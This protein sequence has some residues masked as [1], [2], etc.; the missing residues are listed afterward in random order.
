[1]IHL[2][3]L[4]ISFKSHFDRYVKR[5][6]THPYCRF[7]DPLSRSSYYGNLSIETPHFQREQP[8]VNSEKVWM[9]TKLTEMIVFICRKEDIKQNL[10]EFCNKKSTSTIKYL[11]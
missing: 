1:M 5:S 6:V 4:R 2:G 8:K 11:V 9:L 10:V 7:P 3:W